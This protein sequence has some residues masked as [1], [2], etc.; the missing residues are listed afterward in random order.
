M[1]LTGRVA[2][3]S[4][5]GRGVGRAIAAGL[6]DHGAKVIVADNGTS[7]AG[8]GADPTVARDAAAALGARALAFSDS[9]A[10]PGAAQQLVDLAV[11]RLGGI[12]IVVNNAAIHRESPIV[13]ADPGDWDAVLRNNLSAAFYL[14][15][16]AAPKMRDRR[17]GGWGRIVN[18]L[19]AGALDGGR[20]RAATASAG[21]GMVALTRAA[22][23]DLADSG[24][25]VNAIAPQERSDEEASV[26]AGLALALCSPSGGDVSGRVLGIRGGAILQF[27]ELRPGAPFS[28]EGV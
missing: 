14:L 13:E 26:V 28:L 2:I 5:A 23:L 7:A 22:A 12:D 16:A 6:I 17:D 24:I 21:A 3:V 9:V 18:V 19:P 20:A 15:R 25:T 8:E 10:S 1:P 11:R 4:G 27:D